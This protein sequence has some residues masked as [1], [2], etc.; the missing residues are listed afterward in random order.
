MK[1]DEIF[2][3]CHLLVFE[4]TYEL[5]ATFMRL[6]EYYESPIDG[7]KGCSFSIAEFMDAYAEYEGQFSYTTDWT[8]FNVPGDVVS[9]WES[10]MQFEMHHAKVT[11][12]YFT[13]S[14]RPTPKEEILL[15]Y[16][17]EH[18]TD[19]FYLIGVSDEFNDVVEHEV[20]HAMYALNDD[21]R[22][23][24]DQVCESWEGFDALAQEL[25]ETGY[26]DDVL[27]D[28]VQAYMSEDYDEIHDFFEDY[29]P[30]KECADRFRE[31]RN[32]FTPIYGASSLKPTWDVKSITHDMLQ[33]ALDLDPD[34][35][36]IVWG[37]VLARKRCE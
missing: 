1:A 12:A 16:V 28:E 9:K 25:R 14:K 29:T 8:G 4:T 34:Y 36:L 27:K 15:K 2:P 22:N 37:R 18:C 32:R 26:C 19:P 7:I 24:M 6:Q 20:C 23:A 11:G 3:G 35:E 13:G 5:A 17:H 33:D 21:Y 31:V 30:P 10:I